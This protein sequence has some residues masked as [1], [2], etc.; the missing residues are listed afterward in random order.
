MADVWIQVMTR[1]DADRAVLDRDVRHKMATEDAIGS[2][3][4]A[5]TYPTQPSV[6]NDAALLYLELGRPS[7]ALRHF[8]VVTKLEPDSAVAWYNEG[9]A[10]EALKRPQ[11]A[12]DRY[13]RAIELNPSYSAAHNN[14]AS[15]LVAGGQIDAAVAEYRRAVD[16]DSQNAE[17]RNNLGGL[18][19]ATSPREA[20]AQILAALRARPLF[21]EAHFNLARAYALD[22]EGA[23]AVAEYRLALEQRPGWRPAVYNLAWLLAASPD[24]TVRQPAEALTLAR[25]VSAG[26]ARDAASLDLLAAALAAVG[27]FDEASAA[28]TDAIRM[29][30]A[31][32]Q[33][34]LASQIRERL[35]GYRAGQPFLLN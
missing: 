29:A 15:L 2:E 13:R 7:D 34:A 6:R 25:Q 11:E 33:A 1:S 19:A 30:D 21:P 32:G 3:V 23:S 10:L 9:V 26:S 35:N 8:S 14:L 27:K 5:A 31:A 4:L 28:A 12:A 16:A 22:N 24:P 17:A 18:L 20:Q